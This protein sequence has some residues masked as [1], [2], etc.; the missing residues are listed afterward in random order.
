MDGVD[1]HGI[2]QGPP[3]PDCLRLPHQAWLRHAENHE[4]YENL[5][6]KRGN[7]MLHEYRRALSASTEFGKMKGIDELDSTDEVEPRLERQ[8]CFK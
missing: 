8:P 1:R 6:E 7:V 4:K 2:R 5:V 3:L